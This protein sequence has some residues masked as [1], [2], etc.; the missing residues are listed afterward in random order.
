MGPTDKVY[1]ARNGRLGSV[2]KSF[3]LWWFC[4][5]QLRQA[6]TEIVSANKVAYRFLLGVTSNQSVAAESPGSTNRGSPR[7]QGSWFKN[8]VSNGA[9]PS[10]SSSELET[11]RRLWFDISSNDQIHQQKDPFSIT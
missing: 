7:F 1:G 4:R 6:K 3:S 11:K 5:L 9:K 2:N 8:L 10:S